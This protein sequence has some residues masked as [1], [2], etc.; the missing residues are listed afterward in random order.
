MFGVIAVEHKCPGER[1]Y[2][3]CGSACPITCQNK[4]EIFGC[5][6][7]CEGE[8]THVTVCQMYGCAR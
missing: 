4:D 3:E 2:T 7:V 1:V 5:P 6:A 8:H